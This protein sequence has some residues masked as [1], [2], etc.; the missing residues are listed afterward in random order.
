MSSTPTPATATPVDEATL[1][2]YADLL[3]TFGANVQPGQI[4]SI[5]TE[6]GKEQMTRL[7]AESAYRHGAKFVDMQ[8][9][10]PH[11][12]RARLLH[13]AGDTLEFVPRWLGERALALSD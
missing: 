2:R 3:V 9:Y 12:K 11:V 4:V 5:G 13:A 7:L 10:D 8:Y 6:P 1:R